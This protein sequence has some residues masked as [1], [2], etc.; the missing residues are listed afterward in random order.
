MDNPPLPP[1]PPSL[2]PPSHGDPYSEPEHGGPY[3]PTW[4]QENEGGPSWEYRDHWGLVSATLRTCGEV[5]FRPGETFATAR[6][7]GGVGPPIL[8]FVILKILFAPMTYVLGRAML[9]LSAKQMETS[10]ELLE[11]IYPPDV[12]AMIEG[13]MEEFLAL[14]RSLAEQAESIPLV[15]GMIQSMITTPIGQLI[16]LAFSVVFIHV[17]LLICGAANRDME[18]TF[19]VLAYCF[20]AATPLAL[21]PFCGPFVR[22]CWVAVIVIVGLAEMQET[23]AWRVILA[24]HLAAIPACCCVMGCGMA[25]FAVAGWIGAMA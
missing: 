11:R 22:S 10:M 14:S 1:P 17:A 12:W 18:S 8:F 15:L 24:M 3:D 19:R 21:I 20:A 25:F 5:L 7:K 13:R 9:I 6:R 4:Q 16:F 23:S 2:P